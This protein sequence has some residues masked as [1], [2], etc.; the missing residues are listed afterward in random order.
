MN[1]VKE[2]PLK[3]SRRKFLKLAGVTAAGVASS[4]LLG[5]RARGEEPPTE[6][7][8]YL[9]FVAKE[10]AE[11]LPIFD[12]IFL[13]LN[14]D[15]W[16]ESGD[17]LSDIHDA[18][19]FASFIL[20]KIGQEWRNQEY[21][22]RA[23]KTV[24]WE[25]QLVDQVLEQIRQDPNDR[26]A[27]KLRL[28]PASI[29]HLALIEG[30]ENYSGSDK[31]KEKLTLYSQGGILLANL[32]LIL[33]DPEEIDE[34]MPS[35][36]NRIQA[37]AFIADADFQLARITQNPL[38]SYLGVFL[39][40]Q[41]I[42]QFWVENNYGGHFTLDP[43]ENLPPKAWDQGYTLVALSGAYATSGKSVYL[44]KKRA[45][46]QTTL[47]HLRDSERGGFFNHPDKF[48]K[49]LSANAAVL[50][51]LIRWRQLDSSS[52]HNDEIQQTFGFF[53]NDLFSQDLLWHHWNKDQGR[54]N[55]FCTG[56]NFFALDD[57]YEYYHPVPTPPKAPDEIAY[58]NFTATISNPRIANQLG[59]RLQ[60][61]E[62]FFTSQSLKNTFNLLLSVS[63]K[64]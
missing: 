4:H 33:G 53:Q 59:S 3:I 27:I 58:Q 42:K 48:S 6:H 31:I 51:G 20:Y 5:T 12:P 23:N 2:K 7:R 64:T 49:H 52:S 34:N 25:V 55:W 8:V 13:R 43:A 46:V 1:E 38:F 56:C 10:R 54:A 29:G 50:K 39:T 21:I 45:T 40:D 61:P 28:Y 17:W 24:E 62:D 9:P 19:S 32:A 37:F 60:R 26:Q 22:N 14:R 44:D 18:T 15:F 11:L 36:F 30:L 41:T 16:N 35:G 63:T 57:I 47:A